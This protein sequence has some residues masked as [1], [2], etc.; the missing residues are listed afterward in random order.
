MSN[1]L[2]C[3]TEYV[4]ATV[5]FCSTCGWDLSQDNVYVLGELP[6][7]F[8]QNQQSQLAGARRIWS[9][10]IA[11]QERL[12]QEKADLSSQL[13]EQLTQ[14]QEQL[15]K[16][17]NLRR[18]LQAKLE[19]VTAQLTQKEQETPALQA[20]IAKLAG[21]RAELVAQLA[22]A[23]LGISRLEQVTRERAELF[24]QLAKSDAELHKLKQEHLV[25]VAQLAAAKTENSRLQS[26]L[27]AQLAA[28]HTEIA[29]LQSDLATQ[30][31]QSQTENAR[32]QSIARERDELVAQL[33]KA[34]TE[35]SRLQ[36]ALEQ[37]LVQRELV[38]GNHREFSFPVVTLDRQGR[39]NSRQNGTA[40]ALIQALPGGIMLEMV[41]IPGG[42]FW[43]GS[44]DTELQR[45]DSESPQHQVT[46]S[47][48][49]LGR[50]PVTQAQ[51]AA[52]AGLPKVV[53]DIEANPANF[54]GKDL[55]VESISWYDAVEFCARLTEYTKLPYRLPSEAEWEYACR[56]GTTTPFHFG[57]TISPKFVN[58]D[59]NYT[60][61]EGKKGEY[62]QKT[63]PVGSLKIANAFG[64][65][66]MHGNVWEWCS[67]IW[68]ENYNGAPVDGSAWDD[69]DKNHLINLRQK[70][71]DNDNHSRLL[72]G[73]SWGNIP[74]FCRSAVRYRDR[75]ASRYLNFGFRVAC[76][77]ARLP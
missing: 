48:F 49:Y 58:Y 41:A 13:T 62:R 28:A 11:N 71:N 32:R 57:E 43:M 59:G 18:Q 67:D 73:G 20:E 27:G 66:D 16:S 22:Q 44:P 15:A 29:R 52:V 45:N 76:V 54:K 19:Q 60:Y 37:Q 72:R 35:I 51:W 53:R 70:L 25:L 10:F 5:N 7:V 56:A 33:A 21:E 50:F 77:A 40:Q 17:R 8:V 36:V 55:P 68:H 34:H 31:S 65:S 9:S 42:K 30:L 69:L 75:S 26:E 23:N 39:E 61:G 74:W 3:Q 38:V 1:C 4:E 64:L 2:I 24:V 6:D 12:N 63:I 46:V 47:P 14:L